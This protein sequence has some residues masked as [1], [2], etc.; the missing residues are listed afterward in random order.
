[1]DE[2][3][4]KARESASKIRMGIIMMIRPVNLRKAEVIMQDFSLGEGACTAVFTLSAAGMVA[5]HVVVVGGATPGHATVRVTQPS[6]QVD[7]V[8]LASF[9]NDSALVWWRTPPGLDTGVLGIHA[10]HIASF[11]RSF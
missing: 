1:M 4:V 8:A 10:E 11:M 9:L 3:H 5:P 6:G 7:T 2:T